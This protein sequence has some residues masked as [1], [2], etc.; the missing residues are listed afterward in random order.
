MTDRASTRKA[1]EKVAQIVE[2]ILG[3][4]DLVLVNARFTNQGKRRVLEVTIHKPGST[5]SLD[6]CEKVSKKLDK[7]LDNK[8]NGPLVD[9]PFVLQVQ[10]PG[11]DRKL[12]TQKELKVFVGERVEVRSKIP[13]EPIG[14]SFVGILEEAIDGRVTISN[15]KVAETKPKKGKKKKSKKQDSV[16]NP[17][18]E[19]TLEFSDLSSIRLSPD[20]TKELDEEQEEV[21]N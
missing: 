16:L 20:E 13:I 21:L 2:P 6:D 7:L 1:A 18:E 11:I 4:K 12:K 15:P 10:S 19:I 14:D 17:V 5:V 8:K 3:P 9:G